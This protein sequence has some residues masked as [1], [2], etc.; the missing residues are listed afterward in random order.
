LLCCSL[1]EE[2]TM[3]GS[4]VDLPTEVLDYIFDYLPFNDKKRVRLVCRQWYNQ[5]SSPRFFKATALW[6]D[7]ERAQR[8]KDTLLCAADQRKIQC[9]R[10]DDMTRT[11]S[12]EDILPMMQVFEACRFS[13]VKLS[14]LCSEVAQCPLQQLTVECMNSGE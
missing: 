13:L 10:L 5:L 6:L 3:S 1:P 7:L 4:I 9:I 8:L 12:E 14:F 2:A 11:A